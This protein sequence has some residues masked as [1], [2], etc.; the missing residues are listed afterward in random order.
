MDYVQF[1]PFNAMVESRAASEGNMPSGPKA[2]TQTDTS[3][4]SVSNDS[5]ASAAAGAMTGDLPD[6]MRTRWVK[7]SNGT[8]LRD[9][10]SGWSL[11]NSWVGD[12]IDYAAQ[13]AKK[14]ADFITFKVDPIG[15][16][17]ESFSNTLA[18]AEISSKI[19]STSTS[20]ASARFSF[21]GGNTGV[22]VI[23]GAFN[24]V[25][26]F[27]K[28]FLGGVHL[29]GLLALAGSAHVEIPKHYQSS[30]SDFQNHTFNIELRSPYGDRMSQFFNLYVPLA[31]IL[32]MALPLSTG[33]QSY[34]APF[35]TMA[36]SKGRSMIS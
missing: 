31:C 13:T 8:A 6:R 4:A 36:Y 18:E 10:D 19:N 28:G 34:S 29:D 5:A 30:S 15:T 2:D 32:A 3:I 24:A 16:V 26:D 33:L 14:G 23:D 7:D 20:A 9:D 22:D 35:Y 25:G 27:L 11:S 12:A 1:D 21:S 17:S